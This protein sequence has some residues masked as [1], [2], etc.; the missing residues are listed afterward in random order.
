M[1][2]SKNKPN[3]LS[4]SLAVARMS[5]ARTKIVPISS[6]RCPMSATNTSASPFDT[7]RPRLLFLHVNFIDITVYLRTS[8]PTPFTRKYEMHLTV[9]VARFD[10]P[11]HR[12]RESNRNSF[13]C[14][15]LSKSEHVHTY[16]CVCP[17]ASDPPR[18]EEKL[19][20]IAV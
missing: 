9:P 7:S 15:S 13:S 11:R 10:R 4:T 5:Y 19:P 12:S 2:A 14:R 1:S 18:R 8:I 16:A 3:R 6:S 17:L 20:T